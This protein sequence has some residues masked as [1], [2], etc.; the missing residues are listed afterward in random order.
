[1]HSFVE[2]RL[3]LSDSYCAASGL[4]EPTAVGALSAPS[5]LASIRSKGSI[6]GDRLYRRSDA[7][8]Q[9]LKLM[10][11]WARHCEGAAGEKVLPGSRGPLGKENVPRSLGLLPSDFYKK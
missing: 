7:P 9:R 5:D 6:T 4:S 8:S 1:M 10:D 3:W 2:T 11:A